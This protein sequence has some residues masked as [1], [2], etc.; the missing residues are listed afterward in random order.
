[1]Y[2]KRKKKSVGSDVEGMYSQQ[3]KSKDTNVIGMV[4]FAF[5]KFFVSTVSDSSSRTP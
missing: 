4:R 2:E 1:M 3:K 5:L